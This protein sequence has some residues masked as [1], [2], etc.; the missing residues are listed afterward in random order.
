MCI[1]S[2][3][4][5]LDVFPC[6]DGLFVR[7]HFHDSDFARDDC[8]LGTTLEIAIDA[9]DRGITQ[10]RSLKRARFIDRAIFADHLPFRGHGKGVAL[11]ICRYCAKGLGAEHFNRYCRGRHANLSRGAACDG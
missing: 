8:G 7:C 4:A 5:E 6:G 10:P 11:D 3:S 1:E 2:L 9:Q